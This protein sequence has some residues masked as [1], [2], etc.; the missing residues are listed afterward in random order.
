MI[1]KKINL[2]TAIRSTAIEIGIVVGLLLV[3]GI[4]EFYMIELAESGAD[5]GLF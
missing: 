4:L 2:R 3:G 1:I 5:I